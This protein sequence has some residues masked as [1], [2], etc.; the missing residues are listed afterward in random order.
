M[1]LKFPSVLFI[2]LVFAQLSYAQES[3]DQ[4]V[5]FYTPIEQQDQTASLLAAVPAIDSMYQAYQDKYHLPGVAYGIIYNGKLIYSGSR[6]YANLDKKYPVSVQ[7]E[8]RIASMTKS[9][10]STAILQLR[11]AGKIRLDDPGYMYIP[12]LKSQHYLTTDAP[13]IT[14]RN[15]LTHSAGFPEDNPW[16]DR[17]LDIPDEELLTMIRKGVSFSNVPGISYEYS[18]MGFAMLG[19][20]IKKISGLTYEEYINRHIL[21]PLGM[22]QTYWE[23]S[24]VPEKQL[25]HGYRWVNEKWV[26]QPLLHDGAYGAM[27]G[28]IT[29]MEDFSKYV[30]FHLAAWPASDKKELGPL[31]RSSVREMQQPWVFNNLNAGF[32]YERGNRVSPTIAA[33]GYGLRWSKDAEGKTMIGHSGGLPG[34]GSNWMIMPDYGLAIITFSNHTYA[35]C[36]LINNNVL[37]ALIQ[38]GKLE[39]LKHAPSSILQKRVNELL[40][41]LPEW[42]DA[43]RSGIF[44]ENFFLDYYVDTLKLESFAL[45][46]KLGKIKRIKS[47]I[48]ENNLRGV[49]ILEAEKGNIMLKITLTPENP[50]LIQYFEMKEIE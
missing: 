41:L 22:N 33:Y 6:G 49:C 44:A 4:K 16:G 20:I 23:Y 39:Q 45:Y 18:N 28:M 32:T 24:K 38:L 8:F 10:V 27:G 34:F 29:S 31:K 9:F 30:L 11:D 1:I 7:S 5:N 25:A 2:F 13:V 26:E 19:Y 12:E 48:P 36:T 43:A 46:K 14:I 21:N 42:K 17:Q 40:E 35:P 47:I 3:A 15:L 37:D 50:A